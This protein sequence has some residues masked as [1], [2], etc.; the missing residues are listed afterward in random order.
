VARRIEVEIVGSTAG[1]ERAFGRTQAASGRLE[2]SLRTLGKA[3]LYAIGAGTG[4]GLVGLGLAAHT[5]N[6]EFEL[7]ERVSAQTAAVIKSTGGAANVTGKHIDSLGVSL[8]KKSGIDDQVIESGENMLLTFRNIRNESGKGNDIFD[9]ATKALVDMNFAMKG[10]GLEGGNLKTESIRLGKALN[11]PIRGLTALR[12]VG[13]QFTDDQSKL[14]KHLVLTGHTMQAQKMILHEL[15]L[16]FGGSAEAAGKTVPGQLRILQESLK[17]TGVWIESHF[18]P[19]FLKGVGV[20]GDFFG[21][22][23][24]IAHAKNLRVGVSIAVQGVEGFVS[25]LRKRL[26]SALFGSMQVIE[27]PGGGRRS[28]AVFQKGLVQQIIGAD[29]SAVGQQ[30]G[31]A[32]GGSLVFSADALN[33]LLSGI[34]SWVNSHAAQFATVGIEILGAMVMKLTDPVFWRHHMDLLVGVILVAFGSSLARVAGRFAGAIVEHLGPAFEHAAGELALFFMRGVARLPGALGDSI[35]ALTSIAAR[36]I[37]GLAGEIGRAPGLFAKALRLGVVVAVFRLA[38]S[39]ME[40]AWSSFSAFVTSKA[41]AAVS[42]AASLFSKLKSL[43]GKAWNVVFHGATGAI[44]TGIHWVRTLIHWLEY[45]SGKVWSISISIPTPKLP[46]IPIP[47]IGNP[48][49]AAGGLVMGGMRGRDSVAAMLMPGEVVVPVPLVQRHG[50]P[51]TLMEKLGFQRFAAGGVA[52]KKPKHRAPSLPGSIREAEA[53]AAGTPGLAD[54]IAAVGRELTWINKELS[55]HDLT[56]SERESL[57]V[58]RIRVKNRLKSLRSR[59][60]KRVNT[61]VTPP[62]S[63]RLAEAKARLTASPDDDIAALKREIAWYQ[64]ELKKPH[65]STERRIA[66]TNALADAQDQL[67]SLTGDTGG[68]GTG[69]N[70]G[71]L[72]AQLDQANARLATANMTA[73]LGE[74]FVAT[75]IFGGGGGAAGA[76]AAAAG[77]VHLTINSQWPPSIDQIRGYAAAAVTGIGLQGYRSPPKVR[78]GV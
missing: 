26:Q 45:I 42:A 27:Q 75:G 71:D 69:D 23:G 29:W 63:I 49:G 76:G 74:A 40:S 78:L 28:L 3:S 46:H 68:G 61:D 57:R 66:L 1:I 33:S 52:G 43:T 51:E 44:Q 22:I 11:D 21:F 30:L 36:G 70:S 32:I 39:E 2:R 38:V 6:K 7:T 17:N 55:G 34:L 13:V 35:A 64:T 10:A 24:R 73:A 8:M 31:V 77:G 5:V 25:D 65:I 67:A 9:Q 62:A 12:R 59:Q 58:R 48:F 54:D 20:L 16:E 60:A 4:V 50:G 47:H 72:Q 18:L 41:N 53:R 56:A 15:N 19:V 37:R 14:I